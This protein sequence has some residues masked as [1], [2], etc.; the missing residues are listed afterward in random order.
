MIHDAAAAHS[1]D[2]SR[3]FMVGDKRSDVEAGLAASCA[4]GLVLTGY[5]PQ[6]LEDCRRS[7]IRPSFV[8]KDLGEAVSHIIARDD[9]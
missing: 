7:G 1:I 6:Q 8:A 9:Q 2:L 4:A 3:S 5:G